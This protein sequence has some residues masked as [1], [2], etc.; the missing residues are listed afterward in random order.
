MLIMYVGNSKEEAEYPQART[1]HR[2]GSIHNV[3]ADLI[4]VDCSENGDAII[5]LRVLMTYEERVH[6]R[7]V[8]GIASY[9]RE[10]FNF[11]IK[12]IKEARDALP[13]D[14][15][16]APMAASMAPAPTDRI[17]FKFQTNECVRPSCLFIHKIMSEQEKKDQKWDSKRPVQEPKE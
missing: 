16:E 13:T 10:I 5:P 6:V 9:N 17:Y 3:G 15:S 7:N 12:K 11:I 1:W 14:R 2:E 8:V 4:F